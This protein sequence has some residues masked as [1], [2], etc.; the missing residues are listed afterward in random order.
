MTAKYLF[1]NTFFMLW[2]LS[3]I[4]DKFGVIVLYLAKIVLD[5]ILNMRYVWYRNGKI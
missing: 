2:N 4:F 5:I 3:V 1:P